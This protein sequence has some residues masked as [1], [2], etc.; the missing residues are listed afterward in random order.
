[1]KRI[2]GNMGGGD[3]RFP[4]IGRAFPVSYVFSYIAIAIDIYCVVLIM[5]SLGP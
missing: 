4:N 1:M 5:S 3:A 2:V